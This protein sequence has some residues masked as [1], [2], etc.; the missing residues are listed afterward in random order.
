VQ[1]SADIV[2]IGGGIAGSATFYEL[3]RA[4]LGKVVLV[5]GGEISG[6]TTGESGGFIRKFVGDPYIGK[7]TRESFDYY[8]NF[9]ADVGGSCG[10]TKTGF[11]A[12]VSLDFASKVDSGIRALQDSGYTISLSS[13]PPT[14]TLRESIESDAE[15][16]F[17]YEPN[18]GNVDTKLTCRSWVEAAVRNGGK[19]FENTPVEKI[20][21][22]DG[23]VSGVRTA[24]GIIETKNVVLAAGAWSNQL[25]EPSATDLDKISA[26]SFQYNIYEG[27][28][29]HLDTAFLDA[30]SGV[31]LF[32]LPSG[33]AIAGFLRDDKLVNEFQYDHVVDNVASQKLDALLRNRFVWL[34]DKQMSIVK[35]SY[36]AFT[37]DERGMIKRA[38]DA[39][40]LV[41]ATGM[42]GGGIKIAPAFAKEV[43]KIIGEN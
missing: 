25:L 42:S 18:A 11:A 27:A 35:R 16:A 7:L 17:V 21:I 24:S 13:L 26:K 31:Y 9:E 5:E 22:V 1:N 10:F 33:N 12:L 28:A 39:T 38:D 43:V 8:Q 14:T 32:P 36:D 4:N 30:V 19:V 29:K 15:I 6:R 2:V 3:S 37:E 34:N 40:G 20:L 23:Q 41:L